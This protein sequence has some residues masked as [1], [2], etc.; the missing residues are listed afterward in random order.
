MPTVVRNNPQR[1]RYEILVDDTLA[2]FAAYRAGAGVVTFTHTEIDPAYK[3]Q[4][5][6]SRL[7]RGALDDVRAGGLRAVPVC[8]F[9]T[10][11]L[12]RHPEYADLVDSEAAHQP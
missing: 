7:A 5:L 4:R 10:G 3:G 6:G 8:P 11:Y 1:H 12:E 9:I 2:G